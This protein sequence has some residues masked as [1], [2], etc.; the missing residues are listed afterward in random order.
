MQTCSESLF[1]R[2]Y[3]R[4][5]AEEFKNLRT[6]VFAALICALSVAVTP[7]FVPVGE[8]LRV[9]FTFLIFSVGASVYGPLMA[10]LVG[11]VS[12]NLAFFL[13]PSGPWFFGYTLS[14]MV[15]GFWYGLVLYR[16]R[17][18]MLRLFASRAVVN[19]LVNVAMGS[20]WSAVLYGKGY[21]YY[22]VKSLVKN[23]ILLPFEVMLLGA[24]FA[25]V[26]P[27]FRRFGLLKGVTAEDLKKLRFGSSAALIF[28]L[29]LLLAGGAAAYF[30]TTVDA[31]SLYL[32]LGICLAGLGLLLLLWHLL[33][34]HLAR[35]SA[36][37]A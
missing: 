15:A 1:S 11:L 12:D 37:K 31:G 35:K 32:I 2:A 22:L 26:L 7:L 23:T 17:P 10:V 27:A 13:A 29:D 19:L 24:L 5:A 18:T 21:L 20:I 9:M 33:R 3:W 6:L 4:A 14:T 8:N 25:L 34:G 16:R 36:G 28:G 30:N